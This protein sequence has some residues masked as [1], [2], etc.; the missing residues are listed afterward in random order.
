MIELVQRAAAI[1]PIQLRRV[2]AAT[3]VACMALCV[4]TAPP[5]LHAGEA[6]TTAPHV[7]GGGCCGWDPE[8]HWLRLPGSRSV[9]KRS[10][11]GSSSD[12]WEPGAPGQKTLITFEFVTSNETVNGSVSLSAIADGTDLG[13]A[14]CKDQIRA[15]FEALEDH[16]G[17]VVEERSDGSG[18]IRVGKGTLSGSTIGLGGWSTGDPTYI[19]D[20]FVKLDTESGAFGSAAVLRATAAHEFCHALNL[21]H[22]S[23]SGALMFPSVSGTERPIND[24]MYF[25]QV[26]YSRAVPKI[27]NPTPGNN[28]ADI[29]VRKVSLHVTGA[30][31]T[32]GTGTD[33]AASVEHY[34]L[35]RKPDGSPVGSYAKVGDFTDS[36]GS[37]DFST[38]DPTFTITDTPSAGTYQ[39]RVRAK[40]TNAAATTNEFSNEITVISGSA[41]IVDTI[42]PNRVVR[43]TS[44]DLTF[45]GSDFHSGGNTVSF[46]GTGVTVNNV[47]RTG[48]TELIVD[49]SVAGGAA[50][51]WRN[52]TTTN[53]DDGSSSTKNNAFLVAGPDPTVSTVAPLFALQGFTGDLTVNGTNFHNSGGTPTVSFSGTGITVNS[54]TFNAANQLTANVSIA[55]S[56]DAT[57]FR[58][59]TVTNPTDGGTVTATN[60][61]YVHRV[62][63]AVMTGNGN[64]GSVEIG[65]DEEVDFSGAGSSDPDR[66]N[67]I[68]NYAWD[69]GDGNTSPTNAS[70][71]ISHT[72]TD[73]GAY[74]ATLVVTDDE[75]VPSV[76]ASLLI[77]VAGGADDADLYASSGN[78]SISRTKPN[79]DAFMIRGNFNPMDLPANLAGVRAILTLNGTDVAT[80]ILDA[81]GRFASAK[82]VVPGIKAQVTLKS[83][84][85]LM[86]LKAADLLAELGPD[87]QTGVEQLDVAVGLRF[88][89]GAAITYLDLNGLI[90]FDVTSR[91]GVSSKGKFSAAK[92]MSFG[93]FFVVTKGS[94]K[95][96]TRNG[97]GHLLS[98]SGFLHPAGGAALDLSGDV[99]VDLGGATGIVIPD[100]VIL[101]SGAGALATFTMNAKDP[102]KPVELKSFQLANAKKTFKLTTNYVAGTGIP[103][104]G[105]GGLT[106]P[107]DVDFVIVT[108]SG[109]L[110]FSTTYLL[111]RTDV[112]GT[113]WK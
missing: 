63:V 90:R 5:R 52:V 31:T 29:L 84:M 85:F 96:D 76:A 30:D 73:P 112:S 46:S 101:T 18:A 78:F 34:E 103:N 70:A 51:G 12:R 99:T 27:S 50:I 35:W 66:T 80:A 37:Q 105:A 108:P 71:T 6:G 79:A 28:I 3:I 81:A 23:E 11:L 74:F 88:T 8:K 7:H 43:G 111:T 65:D 104:A 41:P 92:N 13:I 58:S 44:D 1:E 110:T 87:D 109:N 42:T 26:L 2:C 106:F 36:T 32:D 107:L 20:G 61:F 62:P 100:A 60:K 95:E 39:Y 19:T 91:L 77:S 67:T 97:L 16:C 56:A 98:L 93:G 54:V 10:F 68:A 86:Q 113:S 82:G 24:D 9:G 21:G 75:G 33:S 14:N 57:I 89:N 102:A 94:A 59:V 17:I 64:S 25:L 47:S 45:E 69:F 40:F 22:T 48:S 4:L 55:A 72:Y 49:V 53:T 83:K 38:G 15:A